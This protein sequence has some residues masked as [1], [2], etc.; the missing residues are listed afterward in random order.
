[1]NQF[2]V[3]GALVAALGLILPSFIIVLIIAK[4]F[5]KFVEY[6]GVLAALNGLRPAVIG[7]MASA[8]VAIAFTAF[9]IEINFKNNIFNLNFI[10]IIIF[11]LVFGLSLIK[12]LKL[13]SYKIIL[14]S[15]V[16]GI[17]FYSMK[18]FLS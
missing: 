1:M 2:G 10:A 8:A 7:L 6:K 9:N 3:L 14:I 12:K 5:M 17:I 15:A 4:F 16:L 18:D 11:V 13:D